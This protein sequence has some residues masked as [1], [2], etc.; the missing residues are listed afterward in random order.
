MNIQAALIAAGADPEHAASLAV[1]FSQRL[2]GLGLTTTRQVSAFLANASHESAGFTRTS[3]N[4]WY[5]TEAAMIRAFGVRMT[6]RTELLKNPEALANAAYASRLGNGDEASGD[7]WKYRGR[8]FFQLTG[9]A[10][11]VQASRALGFRF[12]ANPDEVA[13]SEGA[14]QTA[15]WF[16]QMRGCGPLADD[17]NL[18]A[19]RERIN[20][21]K[22]LGAGEVAKLAGRIL[23]TLE[24]E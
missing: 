19:V 9:R 12:D 7:G 5:T 4:L 11:Y 24:S 1:P 17:W 3:E 22:K 6:G 15:A 21:P 14:V 10:N 13:C 20:G 8:G 23:K 18:D 2:K 16:W